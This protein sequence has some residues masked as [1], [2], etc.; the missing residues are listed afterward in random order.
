M[1]KKSSKCIRRKELRSNE[2]MRSY[3]NELKPRIVTTRFNQ[4]TWIENESY[5]EKHHPLLGC[6]Y[7]V[8]IK[9]AN[10]FTGDDGFE[11]IFTIF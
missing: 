4:E 1:Y 6:A 8:P 5:R 9:T 11:I 3:C 10:S 2:Q 7:G